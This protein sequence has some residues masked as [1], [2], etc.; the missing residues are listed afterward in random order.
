MSLQAALQRSVEACT[1][2]ERR[3]YWT[4]E[5]ERLR[6]ELAR[7]NAQLER[8]LAKARHARKP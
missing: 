7:V 2:A 3:L 6:R 4:V 1:L 8:E 5:L